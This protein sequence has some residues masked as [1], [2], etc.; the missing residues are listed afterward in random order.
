MGLHG[1]LQ[2]CVYVFSLFNDIFNNSEYAALNY[3]MTVKDQLEIMWIE[4][5]VA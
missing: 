4:A 1:F 5:A 2:G 3:S